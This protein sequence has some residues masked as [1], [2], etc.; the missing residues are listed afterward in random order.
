M[1]AQ[2]IQ[3]L[4]ESKKNT[5]E[6]ACK[7]ISCHLINSVGLGKTSAGDLKESL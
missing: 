2:G 1:Y 4:E 7:A 6:S 5:I 3:H